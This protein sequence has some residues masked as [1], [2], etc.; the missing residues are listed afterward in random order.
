MFKEDNLLRSKWWFFRLSLLGRRSI[1]EADGGKG[2]KSYPQR[3]I[4]LRK[5]QRIF[6]AGLR[7]RKSEFPASGD[8]YYWKGYKQGHFYKHGEG[9]R[10]SPRVPSLF[11]WLDKAAI[12]RAE[13]T[14]EEVGEK[15]GIY[16]DIHVEVFRLREQP[17]EDKEENEEIEDDTYCD[18]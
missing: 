5:I 15:S 6:K 18:V 2:A 7:K 10:L 9:V 16:R 4:N 1:Y 17:C 11:R 13:G 12:G 3:A 8:C 14:D